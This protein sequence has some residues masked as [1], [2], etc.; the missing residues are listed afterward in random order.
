MHP[1]KVDRERLRRLTDLP[2]VGKATADDL[3]LL[4][5]RTPTQLV[6]QDPL[7]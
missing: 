1:D 6:D 2:N 3:L 5:I 4:G 7:D